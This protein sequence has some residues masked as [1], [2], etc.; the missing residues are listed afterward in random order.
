MSEEK[1]IF[2]SIK[3]VPL[4]K[5]Q[6]LS[7]KKIYFIH[8]NQGFTLIEV[9]IAL[10]VFAIGILGDDLIEHFAQF[11]FEFRVR[12]NVIFVCANGVEHLGG[13]LI[14]LHA[15]KMHLRQLFIEFLTNRC[16]ATR[17]HIRP[18]RITGVNM[19]IHETRT[20]H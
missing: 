5:W 17:Q 18:D 15:Y 11:V 7:E 1:I 13:D 8:N 19:A 14:R 20:K 2:P 3:D 10:A 12:E 4:E 9:M 6:K 16:A